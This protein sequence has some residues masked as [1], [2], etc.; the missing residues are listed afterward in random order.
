M[1]ILILPSLRP[2]NHYL[3]FPNKAQVSLSEIQAALLRSDPESGE[4]QRRAAVPCTAPSPP[5]LTAE[6]SPISSRKLLQVLA[7][8]WFAGGRALRT[9]LCT[10]V[11]SADSPAQAGSLWQVK[12]APEDAD[13]PALRA[14]HQHARLGNH[15]GYR[16]ARLALLGG[17]LQYTL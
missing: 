12:Q 2:G 4:E 9:G 1:C 11:L 3:Q 6:L 8:N 10:L 14:H 13:S 17:H 5:R 7:I 16:T 15:C